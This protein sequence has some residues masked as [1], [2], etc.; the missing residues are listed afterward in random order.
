MQAKPEYPLVCL[1]SSCLHTG[2]HAEEKD[3]RSAPRIWIYCSKLPKPR[4]GPIAYVIS[5]CVDWFMLGGKS[6]RMMSTDV[7]LTPECVWTVTA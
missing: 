7:M 3:Q 6:L 4:K 5:K 2:S 1:V